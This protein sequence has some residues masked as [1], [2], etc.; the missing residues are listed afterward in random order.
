MYIFGEVKTEPKDELE[1]LACTAVSIFIH[2]HICCM[3]GQ[4][5]GE[6]LDKKSRTV[7]NDRSKKILQLDNGSSSD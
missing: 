2:S 1:M 5:P 3:D 6:D 7:L 4:N